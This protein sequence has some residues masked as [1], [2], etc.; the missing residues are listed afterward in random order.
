MELERALVDPKADAAP[1]NRSVR[2]VT[3]DGTTVTGRLLNIDTFS[4]QMLD[5]NENLRVVLENGPA[6]NR[7]FCRGPACRP[8][9][10]SSRLKNWPT[11]SAIWRR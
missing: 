3:K 1:Q 10:T 9:K 5:S 8:T 7:L 11:W 4:I 2:V 6:L